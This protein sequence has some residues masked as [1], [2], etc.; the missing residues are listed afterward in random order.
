MRS[1]GLFLGLTCTALTF[2][3]GCQKLG[4]IEERSLASD[5][6]GGGSSVPPPS[7]QC[8]E[9]CDTVMTNCVD[10]FVVYKSRDVCL[11][12][13]AALDPGDEL[14]PAGNTVACRMFEANEAEREP[15]SHC[16]S[17]G[18]GGGNACGSD[19]E[20]W[21]GLLE[22]ACPTDFAALDDC[23]ALCAGL[24]DNSKFD[25][26]TYYETDTVEC[27]LIHVG[28]ALRDPE[29][30]CSHASFNP[31]LRCLPAADEVPDCDVM[32]QLTQATCT[33]E[34]AVFETEEQCRAACNVFEAGTRADRTENT[35]GCRIYHAG[36]A[37]TAP[38]THCKHAGPSGDG[39]CGTDDEDAGK[40]GNCESYCLL[41]EAACGEDT[42]YTFANREEC[43]NTCETDFAE[44]GAAADSGY[45]VDT[46][47]ED[48]QSLQ[49]RVLH[50]AR[51][52]EDSAACAAA[53][54]GAPCN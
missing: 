19:C 15:D 22:Q 52:L 36:S 50:A 6:T 2:A 27:R 29:G 48:P 37:A 47:T 49:C 7:E 53:L 51:A 35:V 25:A 11:D 13:C 46:A 21:C 20:A 4:D 28:A 38:Q 5:A 32:C 9:Y 14:E 33:G 42:D 23:E 40:T 24:Q 3:F 8:T 41:L 10:D 18:P 17:A 54:G 12:V 30:H 43:E 16:K 44:T 39:H 1:F 45:S 34:Y 31:T 26:N